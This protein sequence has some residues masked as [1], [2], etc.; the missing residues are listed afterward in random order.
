M[1]LNDMVGFCKLNCDCSRL[2]PCNYVYLTAKLTVWTVL[3]H[4]KTRKIE[5]S[6]PN[7][8][9]SVHQIHP[10]FLF[11]GKGWRGTET[12]IMNLQAH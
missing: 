2:L 11:Y 12:Q 10:H 4:Q 1:Q 8:F 7:T 6:W 5:T 3:N 9:S